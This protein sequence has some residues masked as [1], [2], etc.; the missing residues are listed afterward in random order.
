MPSRTS[1]KSPWPPGPAIRVPTTRP[2][3]ATTI[4]WTMDMVC[5]RTEGRKVV[6][7]VRWQSVNFPSFRPSVSRGDVA[8]RRRHLRA[9]DGVVV[10]AEPEH[11][12]PGVEDHVT[13]GSAA[14]RDR[15]LA[16]ELR[17]QGP[18]AL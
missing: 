11:P 13:H 14:A 10:G 16:E 7:G 5:Y 17:P 18:G 2:T 6:G 15:G 12:G 8:L 4:H 3:S 1:R 9:T